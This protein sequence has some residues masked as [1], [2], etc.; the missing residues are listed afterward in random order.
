MTG[1]RYLAIKDG[2]KKY[3]M[4]RIVDTHLGQTRDR[5]NFISVGFAD[6]DSE[7]CEL[8]DQNRKLAET[9][10]NIQKS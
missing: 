9:L 7:T 6:V 4:I 2:I 8:M 3:E 5:I 1:H 10:K